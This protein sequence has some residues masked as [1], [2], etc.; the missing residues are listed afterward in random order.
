MSTWRANRKI[1]IEYWYKQ[2]ISSIDSI[3]DIM[4]I[5]I[6]FGNDFDQFDESTAT[7]FIQIND[8]CDIIELTDNHELE[9][10]YIASVYGKYKAIPGKMYRWTLKVLDDCTTH[11]GI[12]RY[13][14]KVSDWWSDGYSYYTDGQIYGWETSAEYGPCL[15]KN[16]I[17]TIHL[18]LKNSYNHSISYIING[19]DYGHAFS[20]EQF[21]YKLAVALY[22]DKA[23]RIKLLSFE[24]SD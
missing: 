5:I 8:K 11:I 6:E 16:D 1:I 21:T 9:E 12:C 2:L 20:V 24:V 13:S 19:Q 3:A 17:I 4:H 10:Y 23:G 18:D 22:N 15:K 7:S 14:N